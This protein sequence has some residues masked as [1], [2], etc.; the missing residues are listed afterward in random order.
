MFPRRLSKK[1]IVV[2]SIAAVAL[3]ATF[4]AVTVTH[5]SPSTSGKS[6]HK[7]APVAT[8]P[9][10]R[11]DA[12]WARLTDD[13][14]MIVG[15]DAAGA[16]VG[17]GRWE[18]EAPGYSSGNP[19]ATYTGLLVQVGPSQTLEDTFSGGQMVGGSSYPAGA[20]AVARSSGLPILDASAAQGAAVTSITDPVI[21]SALPGGGWRVRWTT[22]DGSCAAEAASGTGCPTLSGKVP[23][24]PAG[25]IT[26]TIVPSGADGL[27]VTVDGVVESIDPVPASTAGNAPVPGHADLEECVAGLPIYPGPPRATTCYPSELA[28]GGSASGT[29]LDS[30]RAMPESSPPA[31]NLPTVTCEGTTD[32]PA[33]VCSAWEHLTSAQRV[34]I[35]GLPASDGGQAVPV[36]PSF[37]PLSVTFSPSGFSAT[38][39]GCNLVARHG[40]QAPRWVPGRWT[41]QRLSASPSA[42]WYH[43]SGE[44][45]IPRGVSCSTF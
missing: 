6:G 39:V 30:Q 18:W 29:E 12:L 20:V 37:A 7:S 33:T 31:T 42:T 21:L 22:I 4:A 13:P 19:A 43:S 10:A 32:V 28:L 17:P 45:T 2:T 40:T 15:P 14:A 36:L 23:T 5:S 35:G 3:A 34:V 8:T 41:S 27:T 44:P 38:I 9:Q 11:L 16:L 26:G 25:S 24:I 1:R